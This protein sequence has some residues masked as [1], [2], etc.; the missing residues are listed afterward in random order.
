MENICWTSDP[1]S[2]SAAQNPNLLNVIVGVNKT[3]PGSEDP[4]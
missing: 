2:V 3:D 4:G 1:R